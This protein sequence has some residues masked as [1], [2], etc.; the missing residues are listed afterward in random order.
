M[1]IHSIISFDSKKVWFEYVDGGKI[2]KKKTTY[3]E[4]QTLLQ[5]QK[6]I[7]GRTIKVSDIE[8]TIATPD[9]IGWDDVQGIL[10][11]SFCEGDNIV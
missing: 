10:T 2:C 4:A 1:N 3:N 7:D 11:M 9:V 5:A 6:Y 8:Y